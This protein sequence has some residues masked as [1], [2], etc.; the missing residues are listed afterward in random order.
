M[1]TGSKRTGAIRCGSC[2]AA[3]G[4]KNRF[5]P[6]CGTPVADLGVTMPLVPELTRSVPP[7][8]TP[9]ASL[10]VGDKQSHALG[11]QRK[12]I[13][14][15]FIDLAGSTSI[16]ER[17]DP[18]DLRTVLSVYFNVTSRRI[19]QFGGTI[20][21][22][23][24]DAVMAV[25]G[26]PVAHEDDAARSIDAAL[27]IQADMRLE[28]DELDRRYGVRLTLRTGIN[29]GEVVAGMLSGHAQSGYTA[30]T[31]TGDTVNT[32]QRLESAAPHGEILVS[33][34]TRALARHAFVYEVVP[35]LTLKGKADPVPAYR[36]LRPERRAAPR[37]GV[38]LVGRE[39]E[40]ARLFELY[41]QASSGAGQLAHLYGEAGV[42][43]SR[44]LAEFLDALHEGV[45]RIR[46][47]CSSHEI[48]TPYAL[49][50][51]LLR[52]VFGVGRTDD[53]PTARAA[54]DAGLATL[55]LT[56][57]ESSVALVLEI[58]GYGPSSLDPEAKRQQ[59]VLILRLL[60]RR[61]SADGTLV[62]AFEDL[63][64]IDPASASLLGEIVD[65]VAARRCVLV[66][67]GRER[68]NAPWASAAIALE[69]FDQAHANE[70]LDHVATQ[71]LDVQARALV[72]ERAGGNPFFIEEVVLALAAGKS[73]VPATVQE[74]VAA[75]FDTLDGSP[76]RVAQRASV[77]GRLFGL[78]VL[79][80]ITPGEPLETGLVDLEEQ[81]FIEPRERMPEPSYA[82]RHALV[83][84]VI[85]G[86]HL[87]AQRRVA[88]G[89]VG[90]AIE[91]LYPD[92]ADEFTDTLAFHYDRSDNDEK[93]LLWLVRA[94]DRAKSLFA[95]EEALKLYASALRRARDGEGPLEAG[96][97]LERIGDVQSLSGRYDD[98]IASFG[99]AATRAG[100]PPPPTV[101]RLHRKVGSALSL[102]GAY[103]AALAEYEDGL[104]ALKDRN[105]TEAAWIGVQ[106]GQ[107]KW[108]SGDYESSQEA[109]ATARD[110]ATRLEADAVLAAALKNLG[111]VAYYRGDYADAEALYEQ[112]RGIYERSGDQSGV[113]DMLNNL[114][115][116]Y[117]HLGRWDEA[118]GRYRRAL[119][120]R[121]RMGDPYGVGQM[122]NNIGEAQRLRG[123]LPAAIDAFQQAAAIW[124][125][126]GHA[127]EVPL[128][129]IN[130]GAA[131]V[132]SGDAVTGRAELLTAER[133]FAEI[134]S[135]LYLPDL[136]R[137]LASAELALNDLDAAEQA[138]ERSLTIARADKLRH[139]QGMA[140][141]VRGEIA[142][143]RGEGE[144]ARTL[145]ESSRETLRELGEAAE[146]ARTEAVLAR[147]GA[148]PR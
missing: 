142:L 122:H 48:T 64:W 23:I 76:W 20:D 133:L 74:L 118:L 121:E 22:Y 69:P 36:V 12:L 2:G 78:R 55:T 94:G 86:T 49:I 29:T 123:D 83:Q 135:S 60:L 24:G 95:N 54:V 96:S 33:E 79:A 139:Q 18:E 145:L 42:G 117:L 34:G 57:Q 44:V 25:F 62:I 91:E 110:L 104:A 53:E 77:I 19:V 148:D 127:S 28:N 31:V 45:V 115:G 32:A 146:L 97:I 108:R 143:A 109:L 8:P 120:L 27:A 134:G 16:A 15:L 68:S 30:Y 52:R 4:A 131:R 103:A 46:A 73:T 113:T 37:G 105:D 6:A 65:E 92:R 126:I 47:R 125:D 114:G 144:R 88:H 41:R 43:K 39:A 130:L 11:E 90:A 14:V 58:L 13:T 107:L 106:V 138:A 82:F 89:A 137:F 141:R 116:V 3:L 51:D 101:A 81:R 38:V 132:E 111:N 72:L 59:L 99:D 17:L 63:H 119:E 87:M 40:L 56:S 124:K 136:Y 5:C 71:K 66:S 75:R 61:R 102:K 1:A 128:V 7:L 93:A 147:L 35:A 112:S 67:T 10:Q 26:A 80:R 98:A 21:K 140:E 129:L 100:S 70:M 85:Y 50:A 9:S 84:E